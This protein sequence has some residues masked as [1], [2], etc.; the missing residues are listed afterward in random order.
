MAAP[1]HVVQKGQERF[2]TKKP[3]LAIGVVY[4]LPPGMVGTGAPAGTVHQL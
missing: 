2:Q 3:V 1:S 4:G